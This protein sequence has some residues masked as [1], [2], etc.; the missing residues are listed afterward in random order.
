MR[1]TWLRNYIHP[2]ALE[3]DFGEE[4]FRQNETPTSQKTIQLLWQVLWIRYILI[5]IRI[6]GSFSWNNESV[7]DPKKIPTFF[8]FIQSKKIIFYRFGSNILIWEN[9][10]RLFMKKQYVGYNLLRI[11]YNPLWRNPSKKLRRNKC[12]MCNYSANSGTALKYH[13]EVGIR[14]LY[15][16]I[17][18]HNI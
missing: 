6:R 8:F 18:V 10:P 7:S 9:S 12:S 2:F 1:A 14:I 11:T 5:W 17:N 15:L 3:F 16:N 4:N 13:M